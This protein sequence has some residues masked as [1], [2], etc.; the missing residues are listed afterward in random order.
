M[1]KS[2]AG[3][4]EVEM[5]S[6]NVFADFALPDADKLRIKSGLVIQI[7][8]AMRRLHLTQN[9]APQQLRSEEHRLNSSH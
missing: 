7:I 1:N 5:G 4:I 6:G 2:M 3:G 9:T 8:R